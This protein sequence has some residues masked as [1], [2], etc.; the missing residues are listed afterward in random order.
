MTSA[1]HRVINMSFF[2]ISR[3]FCQIRSKIG[4]LWS[5]ERQKWPELNC[6]QTGRSC[7]HLATL[8]DSLLHLG[9]V[10]FSYQPKGLFSSFGAGN[11]FTFWS[12]Q[13]ANQVFV[14]LMAY[15]A[16]DL[17]CYQNDLYCNI[18]CLSWYSSFLVCF[19]VDLCLDLPNY[20]YFNFLHLPDV[21]PALSLENV[22]FVGPVSLWSL[23]CIRARCCLIGTFCTSF[24]F[25]LCFP[26]VPESLE[27]S[28]HGAGYRFE[29][30]SLPLCALTD[31]I[32][33]AS[34]RN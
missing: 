18:S 7:C 23:I 22:H 6:H 28:N 32:A 16:Q 15:I 5:S 12:F 30:I 25:A 11:L 10:I 20:I 27:R 34:W 21:C 24:S 3:L 19:G 8:S 4:I 29:A 31:A 26:F 1:S 13:F 33:S 9:S 17:L 2:S 14:T